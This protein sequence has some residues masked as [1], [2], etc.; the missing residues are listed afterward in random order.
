MNSFG[1][2]FRVTIFGESHG[3]NIGVV[4][5]GCPAGISVCVDDFSTMLSKRKSGAFGT[6]PR[7]E[8]DAPHIVSGVLN[9]H[10]TGAPIAIF[11]DN[12]D[13]SSKDY[14]SV[15][16]HPRPSHAD[17]VASVKYGGNNDYRGGGHFS[18]RLTAGIVAAGVIAKKILPELTIQTELVEMA[19][20]T[21]KLKYDQVLRKTIAEGD[22]VGGVVECRINGVGIGLGEPFWDSMESLI[23]HAVFAIP[24][25]K[26]VEF[27]AG[28]GAARMLGSEH[29]DPIISTDGKT[30]TNNAGGIYGGISS[31]G[32]ITFRVA[33]KPTASI[34]KEQRSINMETGVVEPLAIRGRHD[35][36]I[37]IRG[38]VVV[39]SM[40]AIVLADLKLLSK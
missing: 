11:F 13:V 29:N 7:S 12:G 39:E 19:G 28:F 5:D 4:I 34:T 30:L 17:Y 6:T 20:Q 25:V 8:S 23:S 14:E 15:R 37:A 33:F 32:E 16:V 18:G 35:C 31:G 3:E 36:C 1:R 21:D 10:A 22:S 38:A 2:K 40:A 27:G 9:N 26:G 24:G